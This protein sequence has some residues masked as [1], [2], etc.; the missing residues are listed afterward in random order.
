MDFLNKSV[1]QLRDLFQSMTPGA[2]LTTG[3][4]LVVVVISLA[5]LVVEHRAGSEAYL[6]GGAS[7]SAGELQAME[8][9]FGEAGLGGYVLEGGR[10]RVPRGQRHQYLAALAEHRALPYN[11]G[12]YMQKAMEAGGLIRS[13]EER[14]EAIEFATEQE[15]SQII[16]KM[17]GLE[18]AAVFY[19]SK[20]TPGLRPRAVAT[21]SVT[22][23]P[24]GSEPLDPE[25]V[26]GIR[27]MV[28]ASFADLEEKDVTVIDHRTGHASTGNPDDPATPADDRYIATQRYHE[29][30]LEADIRALLAHI[31][32]LRVQATVVLDNQ[33]IQ[34]QEKI[35]HNPKPIPIQTV[36][37]ESTRTVDQSAVGGRVGAVA[38][39][40]SSASLP[41]T[42]SAGPTEEETKSE[43]QTINALSSTRTSVESRGLQVKRASVALLVPSSYLE[44]IWRQRQPSDPN[45][46]GGSQPAEPDPAQLS[47]IESQEIAKIRAAV[48]AILPDSQG[49]EDKS[50]LVSVT[51]YQDIKPEPIPE[52]GMVAKATGWL[53]RHWT[54]AALVALVG[55]SLLFLRGMLRAGGTAVSLPVPAPPAPEVEDGE[56]EVEAEANRHLGRFQSSGAS[57]Q[58]E[59][60]DLVN[61]DPDAA[62]NILRAWIGTPT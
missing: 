26:S 39:A 32:G 38:Q 35:E 28:A 52:P 1:A 37:T 61:E 50:Q 24:V 19:N 9:A 56:T 22:V 3:L 27:R 41:P 44:Q 58:E 45:A 18:W 34:R 7:F 14:R 11:F 15:L 49:V 55:A 57:L 59:L 54:T 43:T 6:F 8:R 60:A 21:A 51:V 2:R 42:A 31:A 13:G 30:H 25:L 48:A 40:N 47:Q 4:L 17:S 5:Y 36:E 16:G 20:T 23:K 10:V 29:Q 53:A 46:P 62:A 33:W 12:L